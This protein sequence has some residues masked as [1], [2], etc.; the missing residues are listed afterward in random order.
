MVRYRLNSPDV[1]QET[2]DGEAIIIHTTT[3]TYYSVDGTGDHVW[4]ALLLGHTPEE[5]AAA[6]ADVGH[7]VRDSVSEAVSLFARE[8]QDEHLIVAGD[9]SAAN[10]SAPR[11]TAQFSTPALQKYTDMQELLLVDPIHEVDTQAGWPERR[12]PS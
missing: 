7:D 12:D 1:V 3:G 9:Q 2:V 10:R 5:I 6:Y 4:N 11:P 8:L